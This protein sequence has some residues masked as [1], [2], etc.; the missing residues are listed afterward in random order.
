MI[1]SCN[2]KKVAK[3]NVDLLLKKIETIETSRLKNVDVNWRHIDYLV[4][5]YFKNDTTSIYLI[6][7]KKINSND[8]IVKIYGK[9]VL[10]DSIEYEP[11]ICEYGI[12]KQK[13]YSDYTLMKELG[14][15]EI[16]SDNFKFFISIDNFMFY[17]N[18]NSKYIECFFKKTKNSEPSFYKIYHVSQRKLKTKLDDSVLYTIDLPSKETNNL[19]KK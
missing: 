14:A 15:S 16:Y 18:F 7:K 4:H 9:W 10:L 6:V 3:V 8:I 13:I 1:I 5:S 12:T 19:R 17:H 2:N 11:I